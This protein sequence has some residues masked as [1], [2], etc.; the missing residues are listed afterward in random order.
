MD[1]PETKYAR[2]GDL[3]VAY[4]VFGSG[5]FDL[6]FV[7]QW[8]SNVDTQ[9]RLA[10]MARLLERL[11]QFSRVIVFDKRGTGLSDPVPLGGL[12]TLEEW[13]DDLRAVLDAVGS[14]RTSLVTGVGSTYLALLFAATYPDRTEAMCVVD[15]YARLT[16]DGDYLSGSPK[17]VPAEHVEQVRAGW[18]SGVLLQ[19]LA[20]NEARDPV[21]LRSFAEYERQSAS[22]GMAAAMIRMLYEADLRHILP[23]ISVPTLVITHRD[24]AL[25]PADA[26]RYLA[27]HIPG[28]RHVELPG[29]QNLI[30]AGD[31]EAIVAEVQEFFTGTR[32]IRE[33]DRVLSTVLFTDIVGSTEHA[34]AV[35]DRAWRDLLQSHHSIVRTELD[36]FRGREIDTAGDG[37]LAVFDGPARAVRCARAIV[38]AL[39]A[40]GLEVRAGLHTGEIEIMGPDVGG[41]AV[42]IGARVAAQAGPSEVLVSSTVKDLVVGSGLVFEDRGSQ[43]LKGVPDQWHLFAVAAER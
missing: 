17:Q 27:A 11:A 15:G 35:G 3:H 32:P 25:I 9:W 29:S 13:M 40:I 1:I 42:H 23:V 21:V 26:S 14:E 31:A 8:F 18:G 36:R 28:S 20:P 22:P 30:Y 12:P 37:F 34:A 39:P 5:P 41:I 33:P 10:P 19:R 16:A 43:T 4:Q 7:D 6:T 38:E 24:S 2:A